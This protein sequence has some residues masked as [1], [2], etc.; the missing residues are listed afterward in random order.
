LVVS[1]VPNIGYPPF[2][3][4]A[5]IY[6]PAAGAAVFEYTANIEYAFDGNTNPVFENA[7][8]VPLNVMVPPE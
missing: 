6:A 1:Y 5:F 8:F 2:P 4:T 3:Y 7:W